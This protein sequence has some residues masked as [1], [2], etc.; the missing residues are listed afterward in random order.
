MNIISCS[1]CAVVLDKDC[2]CFPY[3]IWKDDGHGGNEVDLERVVQIAGV[4]IPFT[5]CPVCGEKILQEQ[6]T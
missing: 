3:D 2:L 4:N 1:N 5:T 6:T